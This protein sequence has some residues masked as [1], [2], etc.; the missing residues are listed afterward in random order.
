MPYTSITHTAYGRAALAYARGH[1]GHGHGASVRIPESALMW[2][3]LVFLA[4]LAVV[5][6]VFAQPIVDFFA[7]IVAAI[8]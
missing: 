8:G 4:V 7:R 1:D 3:P 6:G 5:T 2:V